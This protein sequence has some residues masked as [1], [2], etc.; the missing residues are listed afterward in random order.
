MSYIIESVKTNRKIKVLPCVECGHDDI[1]IG[2]CGYSSFNV[3][4]GRCKK[5][6]NEVKIDSCSWDITKKQIAK[7]W[8]TA[9]N[10]KLLRAKYTKAIKALQKKVKALPK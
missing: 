10:P 7:A 5:C 1:D 9:N 4:W 6:K 8:N 3:A 2:D